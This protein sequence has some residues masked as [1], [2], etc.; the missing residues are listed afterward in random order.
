M[1]VELPIRWIRSYAQSIMG[2]WRGLHP[3][4]HSVMW[5]QTETS[6]G[7]YNMS[8]LQLIVKKFKVFKRW[9]HRDSKL[10]CSDQI[11]N[12]KVYLRKKD[13]RAEGEQMVRTRT[14]SNY[15]K[16]RQGQDPTAGD[17]MRL[18]GVKVSWLE[19]EWKYGANMVSSQAQVFEKQNNQQK[20]KNHYVAD[21]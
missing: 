10:L 2:E 20:I 19:P 3:S 16:S 21:P 7:F 1:F 6:S 8:M 5:S 12:A 13:E 18:T 9:R 15:C 17:T 11:T 14:T 4:A